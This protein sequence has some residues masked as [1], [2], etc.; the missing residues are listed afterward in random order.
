MTPEIVIPAKAGIQEAWGGET[1]RSAPPT[2]LDS[3]S[4][5]GVGDKLR[6]NAGL[7]FR[8]PKLAF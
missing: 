2:P 4:P 3:R 6:G 8:T 5:I 1:P 7:A